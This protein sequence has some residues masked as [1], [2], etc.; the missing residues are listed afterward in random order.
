MDNKH[1]LQSLEGTQAH[2]SLAMAPSTSVLPTQFPGP[3][4][5]HIPH[6]SR[7]IPG[8]LRSQLLLDDGALRQELL[9]MTDWLTDDL[10]DAH[11]YVKV[12]FPVSRLIV[13]PERFTSDAEEIM[14]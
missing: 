4:V 1:P 2:Q 12:V 10:F 3:L 13:D 9:L 11:G 5:L 8:E 14:S 7:I 6:S